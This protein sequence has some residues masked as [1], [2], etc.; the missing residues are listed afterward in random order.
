MAQLVR[1]FVDT[2]KLSGLS[3]TYMVKEKTQLH[4]FSSDL[5]MYSI[6]TYIIDKNVFPNLENLYN[7][8]LFNNHGKK[9]MHAILQQGK[10]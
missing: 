4:K 8:V 1:V 2:P 6:H 9:Q 7:A 3:K 5:H 10:P